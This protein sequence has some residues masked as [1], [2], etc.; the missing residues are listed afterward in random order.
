M[1]KIETLNLS[2]TIKLRAA[3]YWGEV[4]RQTPSEARVHRKD[5]K[6]REEQKQEENLLAII[7]KLYAQRIARYV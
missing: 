2:S 3:I 6:L 1:R 7:C 5:Q 4:K